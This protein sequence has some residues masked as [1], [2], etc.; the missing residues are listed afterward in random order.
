MRSIFLICLLMTFGCA[1]KSSKETMIDGPGVPAVEFIT[2]PLIGERTNLEGRVSHVL[3]SKY[4][5]AVFIMVNGKWWS[6]PYD[7]AP[8]SHIDNAGMFKCDITT[9]GDDR[10]ATKVH[11]MLVP[12][13]LD[14]YAILGVTDG[15]MIDGIPMWDYLSNLYESIA[16]VE[17]DRTDFSKS[18]IYTGLTPVWVTTVVQD[19][20]GNFTTSVSGIGI[21]RYCPPLCTDD[22]PEYIKLIWE[23][24]VLIS[25]LLPD[26]HV[27][28][29]P[30]FIESCVQFVFPQDNG[31]PLV[32]EM[33]CVTP[34]K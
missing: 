12:S 13:N 24:G 11:A 6:K 28:P 2:V 30:L 23:D 4:K 20:N 9:G 3:P 14:N 18:E 27:D 7:Y 16:E 1:K 31:P 10:L 29:P 15:S 5:V 26:Q 25:V 33:D 34:V 8:Y 21:I 32:S 22:F 17:Y 19:E